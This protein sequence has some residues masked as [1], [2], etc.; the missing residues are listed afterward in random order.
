MTLD[1]TLRPLARRLVD[2]FGKAITLRRVSKGTYDPATGSLTGQTTA[3][4]PTNGVVR[5]LEEKHLK[6]TL[7]EAGD[8]EI[9]VAADGLDIAPDPSTDLVIVGLDTWD[10]ISV[11]P[12]FS[13]ELVALY[14]LIVRK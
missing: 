7:V 9:T 10:I 5:A 11:E 1:S 2:S 13:G 4:Y 3:D 6:N 12:I 8:M 14:N